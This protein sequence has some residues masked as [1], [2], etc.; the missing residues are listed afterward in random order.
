MKTV[1][2]GATLGCA[3]QADKTHSDV[4]S[5]AAASSRLRGSEGQEE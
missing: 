2:S 5:E 3:L 4:S 1:V